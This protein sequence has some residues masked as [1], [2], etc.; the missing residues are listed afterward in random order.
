MR[1]RLISNRYRLEQTI[2][3]GGMGA[4]WVAFDLQLHRNVALKI[5]HPD[6]RVAESFYRNRLIQE[7]RAV[8]QI[9]HPN[10][11]QIFD[12][13]IDIN[14]DEHLPYLVMELCT[15]E[16][17]Q[18][19]LQRQ[20]RLPLDSVALLAVQACRALSV[21]HNIGLV[22]RDLKPANLF[23][24][25][26]DGK[27]VLKIL[28][29]GVATMTGFGLP[30]QDADMVVGTLHYMSPEQ[31]LRPDKV[32]SR[33][34]L[35]SLAVVLYEALTG[36]VPV[37][38]DSVTDLA[39]CFALDQY[40]VDR[41]SH[42]VDG[43]P[44]SV[45]RFFERALA[46]DP[47][48]RFQSAREF[49]TAVVALTKE[50]RTRP[51]KVLIVDDEPDLEFLIRQRLSDQI[52]DGLYDFV[53]AL[54]G[55]SAL[56]QIRLHPDL[57][58][59]LSDINMPGMDGL[60]LLSQITETNPFLKVVMISAYGDMNNIRTA[61]NK[62]AFDFLTKPIDFRDLEQTVQKTARH[63]SAIRR[64]AA[65]AEENTL[66][67]MFTNGKLIDSIVPMIQ[68]QD[69]MLCEMLQATIMFVRGIVTASPRSEAPDA[70][71]QALNMTF[72][73]LIS[74]IQIHG[75]IVEEFIAG[76]AL[77]AF[78]GAEHMDRAVRASLGIFAVLQNL[79]SNTDTA[80][81]GSQDL[82]IGLDS[83][84]CIYATIGAI[85]QGRINHTLF[86]EPVLNAMNLAAFAQP[87]Q[88]VVLQ[89]LH[90]AMQ[91]SHSFQRLGYW[92][93]TN[94]KTDAEVFQLLKPDALRKDELATA[95]SDG[96]GLDS[97]T[98]S[99]IS[100]LDPTLLGSA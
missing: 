42:H 11:V 66:L 90:Q 3:R 87:G 62:G 12:Y 43:L 45:D 22:H 25:R 72:E 16:D 48:L 18:T 94:D 30:V 89:A 4:V 65:W 86:G 38:A 6:Q 8:A 98:G 74:E 34:D 15:G 67:R 75:G 92:P 23:L 31:I 82:T 99:E 59:V 84:D 60:T 100:G 7:A 32:D 27:E 10:V 93:M 44:A 85:S 78:R 24:A 81:L 37:P 80:C 17:L 21:A 95:S 88:I 50:Q 35:Y 69:V 68:Q 13:G 73:R 70:R 20:G 26:A 71:V 83:G 1:G 54:N 79:G 97:R 52:E 76:G 33:S 58:L 49:C 29:F 9:Q 61:M 63:V 2:G 53:F 51:I 56:E 96:V 46:R 5:L 91:A 41:P 28:D 47:G 77:I 55:M 40:V 14:K 57:D 64:S 36:R 39:S 19:R